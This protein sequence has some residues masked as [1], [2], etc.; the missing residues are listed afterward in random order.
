MTTANNKFAPIYELVG[1]TLYDLGV[2]YDILKLCFGEYEI[3]V[4]C[5]ARIVLNDQILLTTEDYNSRD[6]EDYKHNDMY[7]NI[8][9]HGANLIGHVVQS[10]EISAINDLFI[11]LDNGARIEL[12]NSNGELHFSEGGEQY[13]FYKPKDKAYPFLSITNKDVEIGN[14]D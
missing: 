1:Q 8:A 12:F 11:V 6:E 5:F 4:G 3:H 10:V 7:L 14:V 9:K 2:C 13:F